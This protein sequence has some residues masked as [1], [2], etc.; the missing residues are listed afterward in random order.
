MD[1]AYGPTKPLIQVRILGGRLKNF[2][3]QICCHESE[4]QRK[5]SAKLLAQ[6]FVGSSPT[7]SSNEISSASKMSTTVHHIVLPVHTGLELVMISK[8]F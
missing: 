8:N 5:Q 3:K 6:A 4:R 1:S 2:P 7:G